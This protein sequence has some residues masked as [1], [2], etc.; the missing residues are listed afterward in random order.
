[1]K[2]ILLLILTAI[3][4]LHITTAAITLSN[5]SLNYKV[6]YKWG[7]INSQAGRATLSLTNNGSQYRARLVARTEPWADGI[8]K[9]RDTLFSYMHVANLAPIRYDKI[10]HEDGKFSHDII[11]YTISGDTY[12]GHCTRIRQK[13]KNKPRTQS[14]IS[15]SS[16]G[17][18]V[19]MLSVFYHL[20]TLDFQSMNKGEKVTMSI[21]SGKEKEKLDITFK[22]S[23]DINIEDTKYACYHISFTFTSDG[24][25][26]SSDDIEGWISADSRRIPIKIEGK[27]PIGKIRCLY[28][29]QKF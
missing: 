28:T 3:A 27:L 1:M 26:K 23:T 15:L 14:S 10:A 19:D 21:F 29:T 2:R 12:T 13:D 16:Q 8:Y 5:E 18:T 9:V 17:R 4:T 25:R 20:R 7:L 6:M 24:G 22:G 11:K